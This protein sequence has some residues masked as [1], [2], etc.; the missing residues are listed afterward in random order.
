MEWAV[1]GDSRFKPEDFELNDDER[2]RESLQ[3][4]KGGCSS[5]ALRSLTSCWALAAMGRR[6]V[7][8]E[9]LSLG[10]LVCGMPGS[11]K[12]FGMKKV[13]EELANVTCMQHIIIFDVKGDWSQLLVRR[14]RVVHNG[15]RRA[16]LHIRHTRWLSRHA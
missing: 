3:D 11:G 15:L 8:T 5:P 14:T 4:M 9:D 13:V 10:M 12:T 7:Y 16:H 1:G 6:H 2:L